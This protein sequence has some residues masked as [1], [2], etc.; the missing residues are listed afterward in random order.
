MINRLRVLAITAAMALGLTATGGLVATAAQIDPETGIP[1]GATD[2]ASITYT[3]DSDTAAPFYSFLI[4]QFD[5]DDAATEAMEAYP[6]L[7]ASELTGEEASEE[8]SGELVELTDEE[9]DGLGDLG[10]EA[11]AYTV[12]LG[13][14]M[15]GFSV[16]LLLVRE[17]DTLEVWTAVVI[18][19]SGFLGEEAPSAEPID[20]LAAVNGLAS[21]AGDWFGGDR[22]DDGELID[23]LPTAEVLGDGYTEADRAESLEEIEEQGAEEA[24]P[25]A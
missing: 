2:G 16:G 11:A 3:N 15:S 12:D 7:L 10:D 19:L 1:D 14:E 21:V 23:R 25:A 9:F 17:G 5:D 6:E 24:I 13:E 4:F 22:P 18:D 8:P 20:A